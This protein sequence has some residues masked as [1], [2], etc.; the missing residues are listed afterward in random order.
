MIYDSVNPKENDLDLFGIPSHRIR[1][2]NVLSETLS[3]IGLQSFE[4]ANLPLLLIASNDDMAVQ[5]VT[6][7]A[8]SRRKLYEEAKI[9]EVLEMWQEETAE[10]LLENAAGT[11]TK[12]ETEKLHKRI[13]NVRGAI[14][15]TLCLTAHYEKVNAL[16]PTITDLLLEFLHNGEA[17]IVDRMQFAVEK[18]TARHPAA[19]SALLQNEFLRYSYYIAPVSK[20][21]VTAY[22]NG[23]AKD[24]RDILHNWLAYCKEWKDQPVDR[25]GFDHRESIL[26][27]VIY[28]LKYIDY[29]TEHKTISVA[30]AFGFLEE[31]RKSNHNIHI[32]RFVLQA[33]VQRLLE[34]YVLQVDIYLSDVVQVLV[35]VQEIITGLILYFLK[36]LDQ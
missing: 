17:A 9:Y 25:D 30:E 36:Y 16:S 8:I 23:L 4:D 24:V 15:L 22:Y 20:G 33:F 21:L 2:R 31:L 6:A 11:K 7:A 3:D 35:S 13:S 29:D 14:A 28:T 26:S 27:A 19:M 5:L 18:M 34:G 12:E 10:S 1:I 32:R